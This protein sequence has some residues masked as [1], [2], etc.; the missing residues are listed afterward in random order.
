MWNLENTEKQMELLQE[1]VK[2]LIAK[3]KT[4]REKALKDRG[5]EDHFKNDNFST[6]A[7]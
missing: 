6:K 2:S 4:K 7:L 3:A 1:E 5:N